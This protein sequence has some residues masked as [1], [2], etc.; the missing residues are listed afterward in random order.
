MQK[1]RSNPN[2]LLK[3][4]AALVLLAI[5]V[6]LTAYPLPAQAQST[7]ATLS[8][9]T[10]SPRDITGFSSVRFAYDVGVASTVTEATITATA[11]NSNADVSFDTPD[12][13]DVT[14]GHQVALS[15]GWNTVTITVTAED[16]STQDYTVS[17][18]QGVA[19]NYDWRAQDDL[20]GLEAAGNKTAIGIW[21]NSTT[22]WVVDSDHEKAFAYN[23]DGT[24]DADRDFDFDSNH[25]TARGAWSDG[26]YVWI[27]DRDDDKLYLYEVATGTRQ[28]SREFDLDTENVEAT[29]VWSDDATIWVADSFVNSIPSV[30]GSPRSIRT[31]WGFS[32]PMRRSTSSGLPVTIGVWPASESVFRT[33]LSICGSSSTARMRARPLAVCPERRGTDQVR[34]PSRWLPLRPPG[35]SR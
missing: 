19:G 18:N 23:H 9:L 26:E 11:T 5:A 33:S 30:P 1:L 6:S 2:K 25:Q 7:D 3:A 12:S 20:D 22:I 35:P 32:A 14:D 27:T 10:V 4:A 8:S 21:T 15:A 29:G 34:L 13:N 31:K 28:N 24:R 16:D 17:V